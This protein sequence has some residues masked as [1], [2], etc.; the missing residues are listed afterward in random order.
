MYTF[1]Y[2]GIMYTFVYNGIIHGWVNI[3]F[4]T[5]K[6]PNKNIICWLV[7]PI[8]LIQILLDK[9]VGGLILIPISS[10]IVKLGNIK[11]MVQL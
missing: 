7:G 2:N 1:V 3:S 6:V 9:H 4:R 10:H 11:S 8:W 5:V